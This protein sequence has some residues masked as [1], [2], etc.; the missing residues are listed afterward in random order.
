[1]SDTQPRGREAGPRYELYCWPG[2]QGRGE[3]VRLMLEDA[4]ADYVDVA[5]MPA[6]E[7]GGAQAVQRMMLETGGPV[8]SFA[9]PI[10][11]V[12]DLVLSQT[13]N[14]CAW[15]GGRLGLAPAD[16]VGRLHALQ[17]QLT[18]A[19]V[20]SE[21]HETHH[22]LSAGLYYEDQKAPALERATHFRRERIPRFLG[23][24]ERVLQGNP[25]APGQHLV[26]E[27]FTYVELS[28]F[29]VLEGLHYAF[30]NA[31]RSVVPRVPGLMAL[32]GRVAERPRLAAYLCS[33]R[34]LAFNERDIFR[35][36]PELDE[37]AAE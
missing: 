10:L 23:Y 34:R 35:R 1:M 20:V 30:P 33:E 36:Y 19:D 5:R 7:G 15:L 37:P 27:G 16:E 25:R 14:L 28:L 22:P 13:A 24:F 21:A 26:G 31:F 6:S 8:P 3:F 29:Q 18:L 32:R 9:P 12:G 11:K 2:L 4:G 17:L